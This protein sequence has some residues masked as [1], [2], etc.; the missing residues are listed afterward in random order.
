MWRGLRSQTSEKNLSTFCG[1]K[2]H[3]STLSSVKGIA[4]SEGVPLIFSADSSSSPELELQVLVSE[5]SASVESLESTPFPFPLCRPPISPS[6]TRR[7]GSLGHACE[8]C[9]ASLITL[10][11]YLEKSVY[12]REVHANAL[13]STRPTALCGPVCARVFFGKEA[14]LI[15][16]LFLRALLR[17]FLQMYE[18]CLVCIR[19]LHL[20]FILQIS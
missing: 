2:T 5:R 7:V 1:A 3:S 17:I 11:F 14:E 4:C 10:F 19:P 13:M 8:Y 15:C 9:I 12:L 18:F 20:I 6:S 16:F